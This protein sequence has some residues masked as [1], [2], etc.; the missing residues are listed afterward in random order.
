[1]G[2]HLISS[3]FNGP[4]DHRFHH[5]TTSSLRVVHFHER[6]GGKHRREPA[7]SLTAPPAEMSMEIGPEF[8]Q[9]IGRHID[10]DLHAEPGHCVRSGAVIGI[11]SAGDGDGGAVTE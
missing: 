3:S 4:R 1:M 7:E 8:F 9:D 11:V 5:C 2:D 10:G 6:R